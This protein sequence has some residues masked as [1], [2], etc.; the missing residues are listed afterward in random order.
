M[1]IGATRGHC[2]PQPCWQDA[3][4]EYEHLAGGLKAAVLADAGVLDAQHLVTL[5]G[6]GLQEM[7]GWER[8]LPLQGERARLLREVSGRAWRRPQ[9][10]GHW[11]AGGFSC[12]SCGQARASWHNAVV[13]STGCTH[14]G[15]ALLLLL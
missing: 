1:S 9:L 6:E 8:P 14:P 13:A 3:E 12:S 7:V 2:F 5:T 15:C 4:L 11:R 10:P